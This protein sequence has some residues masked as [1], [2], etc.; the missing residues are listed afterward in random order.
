MSRAKIIKCKELPPTPPAPDIAKITS[1]YPD[2]FEILTGGFQVPEKAYLLARRV[3][4]KFPN[5]EVKF[6]GQEIEFP[7][8]IF[9][10]KYLDNE[11]ACEVALRIMDEFT[12]ESLN[13]K[14][15]WEDIK[16]LVT[17]IRL[18]GIQF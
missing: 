6:L 3:L 1:Y 11:T 14:V 2:H 8:F 13:K 10:Y 16:E 17:L 7:G 4:Q 5:L 18:F 15:T 12:D 9:P